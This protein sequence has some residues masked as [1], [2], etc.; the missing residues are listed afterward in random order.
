M[1]FIPRTNVAL[2]PPYLRGE[3][4]CDSHM[5]PVMLGDALQNMFAEER[6]E[7]EGCEMEEGDENQAPVNMT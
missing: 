7:R 1:R 4:L 6:A 5:A 2:L 3:I